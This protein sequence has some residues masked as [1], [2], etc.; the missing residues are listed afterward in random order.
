[1]S[2]KWPWHPSLVLFVARLL[3]S[4]FQSMLV[5]RRRTTGTSLFLIKHSRDWRGLE[6]F[7]SPR[8]NRE[9]PWMRP[10]W[11]EVGVERGDKGRAQTNLPLV[12]TLFLV[13]FN[14]F[15]A[16]SPKAAV[17]CYFVYLSAART[18]LALYWTAF[19]TFGSRQ[20]ISS[21]RIFL[22]HGKN[23]PPFWEMFY[24]FWV[25]KTGVVRGSVIFQCTPMFSHIN[26]KLSPRPF[27]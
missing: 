16:Q 22:L 6:L 1:M 26:W 25:T 7:A 3:S 10:S 23:R 20:S 9:F 14:R 27:E 5:F 11:D 15:R 2:L 18:R 4:G 13:V 12:T 21:K 17:P 8:S 19:P 24:L